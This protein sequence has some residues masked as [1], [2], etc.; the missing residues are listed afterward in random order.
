M[1]RN[2]KKFLKLRKSKENHQKA[3][4][5]PQYLQPITHRIGWSKV[6]EEVV[7]KVGASCVL[8]EER[9]KKYGLMHPPQTLHFFFFFF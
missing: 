3:K 2:K 1:L 6:R 7:E 8:L 9:N 5:L 4:T